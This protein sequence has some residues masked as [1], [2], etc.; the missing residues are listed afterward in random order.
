LRSVGF[1]QV[2][3]HRLSAD[4]HYA[5][6]VAAVQAAFAGGP[7]ALAYAKFDEATKASAHEEY[8]ESIQP[9]RDHCGFHIPGEFVVVSG[10]RAT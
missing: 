10:R 8:L 4:L 6:E 3:E 9:F 5:D 1:E 2:V 7:V